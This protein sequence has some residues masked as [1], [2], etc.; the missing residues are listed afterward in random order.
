MVLNLVTVQ[1]IMH[2]TISKI[3]KGES[4]KYTGRALRVGTAQ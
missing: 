3:G 1:S 2:R 4:R